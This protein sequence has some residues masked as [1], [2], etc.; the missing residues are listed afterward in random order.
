MLVGSLADADG[1]ISE[2]AASRR[3]LL[4][5]KERE[6][7]ANAAALTASVGH[8]QAEHSQVMTAERRRT[9]VHASC[10]PRVQHSQCYLGVPY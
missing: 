10:M 1:L 7:R 8:A 4:Q 3:S 9:Q 6:K 2:V 5:A